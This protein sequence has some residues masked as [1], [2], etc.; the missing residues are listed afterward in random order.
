V[1]IRGRQKDIIV[2]GGENI[3]A[4]E[5]EDILY[6]HPLVREVAVVAM[7][8]P[9]MVER[10]CAFVVPADGAEV[11]L[12]GLASFLDG[13]G[14]ARQKYPEHLELIAELP[15]TASGKVQKYLLRQM[16]STGSPG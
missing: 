6:A 1:T 12:A 9:V 14:L 16:L 3:S 10:V 4:K 15:T 8:D 5:V 13:V 2:R 11:T 7:P